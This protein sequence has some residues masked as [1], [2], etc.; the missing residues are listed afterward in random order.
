M[1]YQTSGPRKHVHVG[2]LTLSNQQSDGP[3][4]D[5]G[6]RAHSGDGPEVRTL[7]GLHMQRPGWPEDRIPGSSMKVK[8]SALFE[9]WFMMIAYS[10][11]QVLSVVQDL[12]ISKQKS[13]MPLHTDSD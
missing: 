12:L 2:I 7:T 3:R 6:S 11:A 4:A 10:E 13:V 8:G 1:H 9:S 5:F